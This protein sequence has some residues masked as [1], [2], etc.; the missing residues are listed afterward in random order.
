MKTLLFA[1][2]L[3]SASLTGCVKHTLAD[4]YLQP[5]VIEGPHGSLDAVMEDPSSTTHSLYTFA[6]SAEDALARCNED[7]AQL[8]KVAR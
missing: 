4:P 6:G 5:C 1:I 3:A 2:T 7:K 8:R